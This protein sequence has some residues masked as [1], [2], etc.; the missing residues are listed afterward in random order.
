MNDG[1]V[2][3]KLCVVNFHCH[4]FSNVKTIFCSWTFLYNWPCK[5]VYSYLFVFLLK[6]YYSC[7]NKISFLYLTLWMYRK[8]S[9]IEIRL[10]AKKVLIIR[11]NMYYSLAFFCPLKNNLSNLNILF[12]LE[13]FVVFIFMYILLLKAYCT[14]VCHRVK[15]KLFCNGLEILCWT[16]KLVWNHEELSFRQI[17]WKSFC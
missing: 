17:S 3:I 6:W 1:C 13:P 4:F 2:P 9:E 10:I 12:K 7:W 8:S 5:Y 14:Y 16:L 15:I 11:T